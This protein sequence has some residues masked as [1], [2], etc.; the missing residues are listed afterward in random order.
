MWKYWCTLGHADIIISDEG[1]DLNSSLFEALVALMGM[2]NVFSITDKHVHGTESSYK[3]V[4][5]HLRAIVYD[6]RVTDVFTNPTV[7]PSAQYIM[8]SHASSEVSDSEL[9][10]LELTFGS[11]DAIYMDLLK[12]TEAP[13]THALLIHLNEN[14]RT[15]RQISDQYQ[16][17]LISKR[18]ASNPETPNVYQAGDLVKFDAGVKPSPELS[19]RY[20]GHHEV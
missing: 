3:E 5:R 18:T 13:P 19:S 14:L 4:L 8:N 7:I 6:T 12:Q 17:S 11:Q 2:R 10:C 1:P 16:A 20:K 9:T 15:I